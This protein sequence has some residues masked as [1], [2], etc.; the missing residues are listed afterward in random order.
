[1][2]IPPPPV[3]RR[4]RNTD[5][6]RRHRT[7]KKG[8]GGGEGCQLPA[9]GR[10][11]TRTPS[12][13]TVQRRQAD[14]RRRMREAGLD[15]T[16]ANADTKRYPHIVM[17]ACQQVPQAQAA[18]VGFL[19]QGSDKRVR[20]GPRTW[21]Q[22]PP[23][24]IK[25]S[26]I[27]GAGGGVFIEQNVAKNAIVAEYWGD[28]KDRKE[29]LKMR[30][31]KQDTHLRS[32]GFSSGASLDGRIT[33]E[34]RIEDYLEGHRVGSFINCPPEGMQANCKYIFKEWDG[35]AVRNGSVSVAQ[36]VLLQTTRAVRAGEEL[37]ADYGK[38]YVSLHLAE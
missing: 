16:L 38:T 27:G 29:A 26:T 34:M 13:R 19:V 25:I 4:A 30:E 36:R 3:E 14:I 35:G 33:E 11:P 20:M 21:S 18:R 32:L 7:R 2:F 22:L 28:L 23:L 5:A 9:R 6:V 1:M 10:P 8:G 15:G 31:A 24:C 37:F 17:A 12:R